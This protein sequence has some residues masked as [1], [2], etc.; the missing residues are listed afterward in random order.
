MYPTVAM[1]ISAPKMA[2]ITP[3]TMAKQNNWEQLRKIKRRSYVD[4]KGVDHD[5]TVHSI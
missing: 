4:S 5:I 1:A 2:A 3:I